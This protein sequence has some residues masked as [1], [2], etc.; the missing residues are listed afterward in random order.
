MNKRIVKYFG[1]LLIFLAFLFFIDMYFDSVSAETITVTKDGSGDYEKI[2][3]AIGDA[4]KGDTVF[5]KNGIYY[6]NV[7]VNNI[8]NLTGESRENSVIDGINIGDVVRIESDHVNISSFKIKN[9]GNEGSDWVNYDAGVDIGRSNNQII[10]C[11]ISNN[12]IGIYLYW[13]TYNNQITNCTIS[14]N[15]KNGIYLNGISDI[16]ITNCT[17]SKNSDNGIYLDYSLK[18]K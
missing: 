5:V 14:N 15:S 13:G 7:V 8:I 11:I 3:D 16:K 4:K 6:E 1:I 2:Q 17:I 12:S 18:I 10:N 9:S